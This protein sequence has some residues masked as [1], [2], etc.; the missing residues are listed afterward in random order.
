MDPKT[1]T[2]SFTK[3]FQTR[4]ED[5]D[6]D[7]LTTEDAQHFYDIITQEIK[8]L[9]NARKGLTTEDVFTDDRGRFVIPQRFRTLLGAKGPTHFT[10]HI[11]RLTDPRGL[12][13]VKEP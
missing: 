9:N 2:P 3:W 10:C 5:L 12:I 8:D 13:I 1:N 4:L 7:K 6:A 11:D